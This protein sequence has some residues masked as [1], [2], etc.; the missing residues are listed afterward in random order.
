MTT[1]QI[2]A[3]LKKL[4]YDTSGLVSSPTSNSHLISKDSNTWAFE[5]VYYTDGTI[6]SINPHTTYIKITK[7]NEIYNKTR[8]LRAPYLKDKHYENNRL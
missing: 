8:K 7:K 5:I 2:K 4:G 1:P 6:A 3:L